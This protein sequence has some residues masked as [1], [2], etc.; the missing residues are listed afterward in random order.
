VQDLISKA[1]AAGVDANIIG[2]ET[3]DELLGDLLLLIPD[4]PNDIIEQLRE[5]KPR[6]SDAPIPEMMGTYP[7]IRLNALPILSSPSLC[8][9]VICKIGGAKEVTDTI[10]NTG[11]DV[12]ATRRR[13]GIIAFGSDEEIRKAFG[14]HNIT[15]FDLHSIEAHRLQW[16]SAEKGLIYEALCRALVR[17]RNLKMVFRRSGSIVAVDPVHA[18]EYLFVKLKDAAR[19]ITGTVPGTTVHWSEAVRLRL[20]YRLEKL[21]LLLEP[22]IWVNERSND[23]EIK[24]FIRARL[25]TRYNSVSNTIIAAWAQIITGGQSIGQINTFGITDGVDASFTISSVTAFSKHG[26]TE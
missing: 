17:E 1:S 24:E 11:T 10:K 6:V 15:G 25:A 3:F 26:G 22:T 19:T 2:I 16:E 8:R 4:T 7:W 5:Q 21:W 13:I 14:S 23:P 12:I 9:R 18:G 20:E